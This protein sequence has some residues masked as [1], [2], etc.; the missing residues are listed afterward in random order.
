MDWHTFHLVFFSPHSIEIKKIMKTI[1]RRANPSPRPAVTVSEIEQM[2]VECHRNGG[3]CV[4]VACEFSGRERDAFM[5]RGIFAVSCDLLPT[6]S[7]CSK[8]IHYRGDVRDLLGLGWDMMIAH[9]P[10]TYLCSSGLH[11]CTRKDSEGNL[12]KKA[13]ERVQLRDEALAF[14]RCLLAAPIP[15]IVLEN[16]VGC[17]SS[18]IR[19]PDQSIQPWQHGDPESKKTCFWYV[20][21]VP[22]LVPT[23][24]LPLPTTGRWA[25]QT[26]T[27]QNNL[28]P[29]K[30]RW[31]LRSTTYRGIA[32][33]MAD[34][35][36]L[37]LLGNK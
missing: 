20:G 29:S 28:P 14:V 4:L 15:R 27:G 17:I 6:D 34:Q 37:I 22:P 31:K 1:P 35:W 21:D 26:P 19:K 7:K 24:V 16:P 32:R 9:P 8:G 18:Q 12:T 10:C 25:N 36:G 5:A 33:A 13:V 11:W 30:D 3:K 2:V 23:Q